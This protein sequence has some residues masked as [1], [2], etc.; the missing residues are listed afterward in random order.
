MAFR[1]T[2]FSDVCGTTDE[3]KKRLYEEYDQVASDPDGTLAGLV[4]DAV[5]MV[6]R[7][8][9][10]LEEYRSLRERVREILASMETIEEVGREKAE[11]AERAIRQR[12]Q[13]PQ[14]FEEARAEEVDRAA[15]SIRSVASKQER[16]L[17]QYKDQALRLHN[18]FMQIKGNRPWLVEEE[19]EGCLIETLRKQYQA[20]LPPPPHAEHLLDWLSRARA[21]V[22]ETASPDGQPVVQ[23]EDGGVMPM[24]QV[25]WDA[26]IGNFHPASFE[27]GAAARQYRRKSPQIFHRKGAEDA[28]KRQG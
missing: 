19:G 27:P 24:S 16:T 21:V 2:L 20:W 4:D 15:E 13:S 8:H 17:R 28:A 1:Q 25:R 6:G 5:Y 18:A 9:Q 26:D 23:F 11:E 12:I 14:A 3:L 7:M 22:S 10:R